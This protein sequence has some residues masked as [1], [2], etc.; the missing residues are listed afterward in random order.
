MNFSANQAFRIK[1]SNADSDKDWMI[2]EQRKNE[3]LFRT[4][5]Q[6]EECISKNGF[7]YFDTLSYD[8]EHLPHINDV[9]KKYHFYDYDVRRKDKGLNPFYELEMDKSMNFS[10]FSHEDY[11]YFLVRLRRQLEYHGMDVKNDLKYFMSC[12]YGSDNVYKDAYGRVRKGTKRPHYHILFFVNNPTIDGFEFSRMVDK[13]WQKGR[14]DGLP[15]KSY[16]YVARHIFRAGTLLT[17]NL[18]VRKV[19]NYVA[20][21]VNKD[22]EWKKLIEERLE[23]VFKLVYNDDFWRDVDLR[24]KYKKLVR[25]IDVFH[26]QSHGFGEYALFAQDEDEIKNM[27][28]TGMMSM[29]DD[30][31]GVHGK[32]IPI[33]KYYQMKI[34][35]IQYRDSNGSLRWK[36]TELGSRFGLEQFKRN[37]D[38]QKKNIHDWFNAN[39]TVHNQFVKYDDLKDVDKVR[40]Q[41]MDWLDGR[42]LDDYVNYQMIYKGRIRSRYSMDTGEVDDARQMLYNRYFLDPE[43]FAPSFHIEQKEV[44]DKF[45]PKG[46]VLR[47]SRKLGVL[48]RQKDDYVVSHIADVKVMDDS[49]NCWYNYATQVDKR[50]FGRRFIFNRDLGDKDR[51]YDYSYGC[52]DVKTDSY[53]GKD[54]KDAIGYM[55]PEVFEFIYCYN[56]NSHKCFKNFDDIERLI[57][58]YEEGWNENR[59]KTYESKNELKKKLADNGF[60]I[61]TKI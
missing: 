50:Q 8:D 31:K 57:E 5:W 43:E 6:C 40:K 16:S 18:R 27:L 30:K 46:S 58:R 49:S 61:H 23:K 47:R 55:T 19:C 51:G 41:I 56:Q 12:E 45:V 35:W 22:G 10:C 25:D 54:I 60:Y 48:K 44:V 4:Y 9:F 24:D 38:R 11:R 2:Q 59:Q 1:V 15:Y 32:H 34:F 3:W 17:D 36:R 42:T 13:C 33:P 14:T 52:Y 20:K 26:R 39:I 29:P 7:V 53:T 28:N 37:L 21:Y